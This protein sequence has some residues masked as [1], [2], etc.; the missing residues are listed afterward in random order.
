[1]VSSLIAWFL[2]RCMAFIEAVEDKTDDYYDA[3]QA[4]R[5]ARERERRG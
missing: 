2:D 3:R 5:E 4:R 1:M